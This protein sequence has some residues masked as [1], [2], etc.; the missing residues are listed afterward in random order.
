MKKLWM[1]LVVIVVLALSQVACD[2]SG[3]IQKT[4]CETVFTEVC[5]TL[6]K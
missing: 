1:V 5:T 3:Q 6:T 4:G 2:E